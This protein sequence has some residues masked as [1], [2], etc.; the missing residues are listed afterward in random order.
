MSTTDIPRGDT[1]PRH[2]KLQVELILEVT[3]TEELTEA[4]LE[5][6][7]DDELMP[8]EERAHAESAVRQDESEALA[9]LVD[10]FDLVTT[11]PGVELV[12]ASWSCAHTEYD[13]D[14][15]EEWDLYEDEEEEEGEEE[16]GIEDEDVE[17]IEDVED[18]NGG[19]GTEP[20]RP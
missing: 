18:E 12:R 10:P 3:D 16:D 17:D 14:A 19:Q 2:V 4:A 7:G 9:Y 15:D 5:H 1:G 6:I 20:K 11:V 8:Q 13:P